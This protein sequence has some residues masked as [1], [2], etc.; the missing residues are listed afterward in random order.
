MFWKIKVHKTYFHRNIFS[1]NNI[2]LLNYS[3]FFKRGQKIFQDFAALIFG[4]KVL[5]TS[6]CPQGPILDYLQ[7]CIIWAASVRRLKSLPKSGL[8][9]IIMKKVIQ[10]VKNFARTLLKAKLFMYIMLGLHIFSYFTLSRLLFCESLHIR[11][12]VEAEK[13]NTLY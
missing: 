13:I 12:N 4:E 1:W 9:V 8:L 6:C 10:D 11:V 5:R 7:F 2:S 3:F